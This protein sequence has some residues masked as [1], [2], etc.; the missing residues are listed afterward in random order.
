[1]VEKP[2]VGDAAGCADSCS[3]HHHHILTATELHQPSHRG[4]TASGLGLGSKRSRTALIRSGAR[5]LTSL[6]RLTAA[7]P[8]MTV[9]R[10][11]FKIK[12]CASV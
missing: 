2:E 11:F 12:F 5:G 4:Q 7:I 10:I 3:G 1:M 9:T 6:H 8:N